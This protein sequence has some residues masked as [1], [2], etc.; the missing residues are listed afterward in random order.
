MAWTP[1]PYHDE[2]YVYDAE[3]LK[4]AWA[5]LHAGDA[6]PFPKK[7]ALVDAWIAYHAGQF[8][9]AARLG[10]AVGVDGY[11]VAHK[12]SYVNATYLETDVKRR[13]ALYE[14]IAERCERQQ[15]EQ[16][17]NPAGWYWQALALGRYSQGISIV[18]AL[19]QGIAP[20]V[21]SGL[22]R[23]IRLSPSHAEARIGLGVYHAEI[24][25]SVGAMIG[26]LTY[27]ARK[28]DCHQ[29]FRKALELNPAS[30][31]AYIEYANALLKLEG[32]TKRDEALILYR[33]AAALEPQ[34]AKERLEVGLA[35]KHLEEE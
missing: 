12:A 26:A 22:E 15:A 31:I 20:K 32:K 10:L 17:D 1:F 29:A 19:A 21:R 4:Q 24:I 28:D 9:Q 11:S 13:L 6:E 14:E 35:K 33:Q 34:D 23:T 8:Q 3:R 5:R 25:A 30:P 18:K 7:A 27:G 16:P 2:A